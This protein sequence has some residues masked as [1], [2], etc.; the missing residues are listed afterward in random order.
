[1]SYFVFLPDMPYRIVAAEAGPSA[2]KALQMAFPEPEFRL[3]FVEDPARL[4]DTV[5]GMAPDA[6]LL[7]L[8]LPGID[9]YAAAGALARQEPLRSVPLFLLKGTFELVDRDKAGG[10]SVEGVI[11]KPFDGERLAATVR[12]SI[13]RK[14]SPPTMP[15]ELPPEEPAAEAGPGAPAAPRPVPGAESLRAQVRGLVRDEVLDMERELEKRLRARLLAE[16][17]KEP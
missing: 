12:D 5:A 11:Q 3:L 14:L 16:L 4:V 2:Q 13:D 1:M 17:G 15:E 8:S 10:L 9:V 7:A 6:I